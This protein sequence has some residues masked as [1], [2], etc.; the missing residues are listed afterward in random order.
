MIVEN[1]FKQYSKCLNYDLS[2]PRMQI[3]TCSRTFQVL[4]SNTICPWPKYFAE[5]PTERKESKMTFEELYLANNAW[6]P[7][8]VIKVKRKPF[9][10]LCIDEI[11]CN[12]AMRHYCY[13][14][15]KYFHGNVVHIID[16][17]P[18]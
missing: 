9:G 2:S 3:G 14:Q 5:R 17:P 15:I 12:V 13:N 11:T 4:E 16:K 1:F 8:T 10:V 7:K 6:T 18:K